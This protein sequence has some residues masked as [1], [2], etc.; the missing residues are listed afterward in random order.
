MYALRISIKSA[1]FHTDHWEADGEGQGAN[2]AKGAEDKW[3]VFIVVQ[4][5]RQDGKC[6][7]QTEQK[8]YMTVEF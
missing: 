3:S 4:R 6:A 8:T 2:C 5:P 7:C 1:M